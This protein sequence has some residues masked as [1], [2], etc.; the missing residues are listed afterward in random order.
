MIFQSDTNSSHPLLDQFIPFGNFGTFKIFRTDSWVI[1]CT[2]G[3]EALGTKEWL[4]SQLRTRKEAVSRGQQYICEFIFSTNTVWKLSTEPHKSNSKLDE[5]HLI[6][7]LC[8]LILLQSALKNANLY[9]ETYTH[10]HFIISLLQTPNWC[11]PSDVII[12][13]PRELSF[14]LL[15]TYI[16]CVAAL[17]K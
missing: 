3:R 12:I 14:S 11:C 2:G 4:T 15:S 13:N 9:I 17:K 6:A 1:K 7:C 8:N 16:S 5:E 10:T